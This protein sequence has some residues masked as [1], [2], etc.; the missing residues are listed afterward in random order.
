MQIPLDSFSKIKLTTAEEN[1]LAKRIRTGDEA[2]VNA[3][4]MA[5]MREAV[6]YVRRCVNGEIPDDELISL[7]Y[8]ILVRCARRFKPRWSRFIAFSKP[9][10]RGDV[11]R[12]W[13][14]KDAVK[15]VPGENIVHPDFKPRPTRMHDRTI[16][17]D[18]SDIVTPEHE[19]TE[20]VLGEIDGKETWSALTLLIKKICSSREHAVLELVYQGGL[21][22]QEIAEK[23]GVTRSAIQRTHSVA[24][25]K[26]RDNLGDL[27]I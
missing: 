5:S 7:C 25:K 27:A 24:L 1:K 21:N 2:A 14:E 20:P 10:L 19:I 26:L 11:R 18:D 17:W 23:L 15:G 4:V 8:G 12:S 3:L 6:I 16:I 13:K 22:F 9:A